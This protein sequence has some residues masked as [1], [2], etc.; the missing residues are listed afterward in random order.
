[1]KSISKKYFAFILIF[2]LLNDDLCIQVKANSELL[3]SLRGHSLNEHTESR[4][5]NN[6]TQNSLDHNPARKI[7]QKSLSAKLRRLKENRALAKSKDFGITFLVLLGVLIVAGIIKYYMDQRVKK[8]LEFLSNE[9]KKPQVLQY[10]QRIQ[11]GSLNM[12]Y[13]LTLQ[14]LSKFSASQELM[15][16]VYE[17][18]LK[19][20][21]TAT[22]TSNAL[23]KLKTTLGG[24][25]QNRKATTYGSAMTNDCYNTY[26]HREGAER[27]SQ[28]TQTS[29]TSD[30]GEAIENLDEAIVATDLS[31]KEF[32]QNEKRDKLADS[33][34]WAFSADTFEIPGKYTDLSDSK[35][36][37]T[38]EREVI[39][40][41][42]DEDWDG[43]GATDIVGF[44]GTVID[45]GKDLIEG[46]KLFKELSDPR[47]KST[48][49]VRKIFKVLKWIFTKTHNVL[50]LTGNIQKL[51]GAENS[52]NFPFISLAA[53]VASII[54]KL[55]E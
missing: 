2:L 9:K 24:F 45:N 15:S 25:L 27:F 6:S 1:M 3:Q 54:E 42:K 50:K 4:K 29:T 39:Q 33:A 52:L 13:C 38:S 17:E 34:D 16:K 43:P 19:Q 7:H 30:E 18:D 28:T 8:A 32:V 49:L 23:K 55:L 22:S 12:N 10:Y 14:T 40:S 46:Y 35:K 21:L 51:L 26:K 20:D 31:I 41:P 44:V 11:E 37:M 36:S 47:D 5:K 48:S 53:N